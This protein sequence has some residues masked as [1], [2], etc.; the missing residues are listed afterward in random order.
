MFPTACSFFTASWSHLVLL[1]PCPLSTPS[2]LQLTL[3]PNDRLMIKTVC[4]LKAEKLDLTGKKNF[5]K[6]YQLDLKEF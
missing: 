5:P 4:L 3:D 1:S 2:I 6:H